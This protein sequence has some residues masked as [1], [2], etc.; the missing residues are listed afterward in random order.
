MVVQQDVRGGEDAAYAERR[1]Q[2]L[3][4]VG[5]ELEMAETWEPT[6]NPDSLVG[7]L[8]RM[9]D[10]AT[11]ATDTLSPGD[12]ADIRERVRKIK[13]KTYQGHIDVL[14]EQAMTASRDKERQAQR[15]E[16]ARQINDALNVAARLGIP[17]AIK[18]GIKER[19]D[20][21]GQTSAAGDS[22]TAKTNAEREAARE[23]ARVDVGAHPREHRTFTRW[24]DPSLVIELG[25][26]AFT[27]VDWSL[28]GAL[29]AEVENRGW[30]CGQSIDVKIG[31]S[32]GRLHPDKMVVVRY[33]PETKRLAIRARR[34]ASVLMQVKRDCDVAGI[35]VG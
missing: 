31:L 21:I 20:I 19:L 6:N 8:D 10:A 26:R 11:N 18:D 35:Q 7:H 17:Q 15:G 34:F 2:W 32:G 25:G 29:V 3:E 4:R 1:R 23:A 24:R 30:K 14:L 16:L 22:T 27:T 12:Q 33:I 28:G 13:L 9:V 5:R